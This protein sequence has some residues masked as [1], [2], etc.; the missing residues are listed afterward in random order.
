MSPGRI[1]PGHPGFLSQAKAC[2]YDF[3]IPSWKV[4]LIKLLLRG[5]EIRALSRA[6]RDG[7]ANHLAA[8]LE[9]RELKLELLILEPFRNNVPSV[10]REF[11]VSTQ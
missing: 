6:K 2:G 3:F 8:S 11:R 10:E 1:N 9:L 5:R 4:S 7:P